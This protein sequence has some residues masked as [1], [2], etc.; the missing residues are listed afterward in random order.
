MRNYILITMLLICGHTLFAQDRPF[1]IQNMAILDS[2]SRTMEYEKLW[3]PYIA[4]GA[5]GN[6]VVAY[7]CKLYGK[8]DMGDI[9]VTVSKNK[10]KTWSPPVKIFD[11]SA[12]AGASRYAY[13]NPILFRPE[14]QQILWC[15]AMRC[16]LFYL[17]S[18]DSKLCA[19]YSCD[20]GYSWQPVELFMRF[21]SPIIVNDGI[22]EMKHNGRSVYL[23]PVHRNTM[24]HDPHGDRQQFVLQSDNL[25][26]WD[27]AG[28]IPAPDSV[29]VHEG[30]LS[31]DARGDMT[32][33]M[34]T[35][36]NIKKKECLDLPRAYSSQSSDNGKTW[37]FANAEPALYNASSK[38][39]YRDISGGRKIYVYNDGKRSDRLAMFYTIC[40]KDGKW[41]EPALFYYENNKNSYPTLLEIEPGKF[42]CVWD[43]S[44]NDKEARQCIR[45]A[46]FDLN[47]QQSEK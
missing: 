39:F 12:P 45:F 2:V 38:A 28:Y 31:V 43:S 23:L 6:Y 47:K 3:Q 18:E 22:T 1:A 11:H 42:L 32:I 29:W 9:C 27:L 14:G 15:F 5:E 37:S 24:R 19:A 25:I 16:P 34:R 33:V 20:G 7:G 36:K 10:G 8:S 30:Q 26:D 46:T 40:S 35:A 17:D 44:Y 41:S 13:A 21:Q 4:V